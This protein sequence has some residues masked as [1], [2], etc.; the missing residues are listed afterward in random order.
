MRSLPRKQ[1]RANCPRPPCG[2]CPVR[3]PRLPLR[4]N[5]TCP[6]P[7][8]KGSRLPTWRGGFDSRRALLKLGSVAQRQSGCLLSDSAWVRVPPVPLTLRGVCWSNG[9]AFGHRPSGWSRRR[10]FD[11]CT[12][13]FDD[14]TNRTPMRD[15]SMAGRGAL[16]AVMLVRVQLP[17]LRHCRFVRATAWISD[18]TS[19]TTTEVNRPD[20]EPVLKTGAGS[21]SRPPSGRCPV[22]V[23]RLPPFEEQDG[24]VAQRRRQLPYKETIGGSSPP[25][26]TF[27]GL[28]GANAPFMQSSG[29]SQQSGLGHSESLTRLG[30]QPADHFDSNPEM[31][32]PSGRCPVRISRELLRNTTRPC[33]AARSARHPVTVEIVGSN[34]IGGAFNNGSDN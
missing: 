31:R 8:G 30:R 1:V 22:R 3:V 21:R 25:R 5:N 14:G 17:Q 34:P 28:F 7:S 13:N 16:N 15:R 23:P 29:S 11:S 6:W 2:R 4:E 12:C 20:E 32:P 10:G 18:P 33:G 19:K 26:T 24:P 9:V 27:G